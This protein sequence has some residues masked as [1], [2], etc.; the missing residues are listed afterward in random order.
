MLQRGYSKVP[1]AYGFA[2]N[3][4]LPSTIVDCRIHFVWLTKEVLSDIEV[5]YLSLYG[6]CAINKQSG[7]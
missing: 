7:S 2:E 3:M 5:T 4:T 6:K 1:T